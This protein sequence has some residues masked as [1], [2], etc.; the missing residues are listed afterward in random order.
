MDDHC[1]FYFSVH[2]SFQ[3]K[4]NISSTRRAYRR[5]N[6]Q[7][8]DADIKELRPGMNRADSEKV[9]EKNV[10]YNILTGSVIIQADK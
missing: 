1:D 8:R 4:E 10:Y 5:L 3:I 2:V 7:G 6:K 9:P